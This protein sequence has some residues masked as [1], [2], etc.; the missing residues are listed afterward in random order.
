MGC[1]ITV[2]LGLVNVIAAVIVDRQSQARLDDEELVQMVHQEQ[3]K[4]SYSNLKR[5]FSEMDA[6]ASGVLS[7]TEIIESYHTQGAFRELLNSMD[8]DGMD[9]E[10][11]FDILD[12]D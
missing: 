10:N 2:N 12:A 9:L 11:V 6:D 5:L 7:R 1:F 4:A 8:I 3:L